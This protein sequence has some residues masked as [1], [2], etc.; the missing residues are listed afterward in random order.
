MSQ[1]TADCCVS[2]HAGTFCWSTAQASTSTHM[3]AD[4]LAVHAFREWEPMCWT[5][6]RWHSV[7]T[8]LLYV[9]R[10]TRKV[11]QLINFN[12]QCSLLWCLFNTFTFY[13]HRHLLFGIK[14]F[15]CEFF[16][17]CFCFFLFLCL[18]FGSR[19]CCIIKLKLE[20]VYCYTKCS[21]IHI[22]M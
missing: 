17:V 15:A 22:Y 3:T 14:I 6:R 2:W 9:T 1:M 19:A 12:I 18:L 13:E 4:W 16:S 7:M 11:L 8:H 21:R 10:P 5:D 20:S